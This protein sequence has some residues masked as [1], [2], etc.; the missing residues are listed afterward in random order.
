[1]ANSVT[2]AA[3]VQCSCSEQS[4]ALPARCSHEGPRPARAALLQ[5]ERQQAAKQAFAFTPQMQQEVDAYY[6]HHYCTHFSLNAIG[7]VYARIP[8]V[9]HT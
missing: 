6:F 5:D 1:M 7:E 9:K 3:C 2:A 4:P 8:Q